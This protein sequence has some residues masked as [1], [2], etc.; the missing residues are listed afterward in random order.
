MADDYYDP[1]LAYNKQTGGTVPGG[2]QAFVYAFEDTSFTTPL[3]ITDESGLPIPYLVASDD[4]I[5]PGF[6]V[7]SGQQRVRVKSGDFVTPMTSDKGRKGDAG[8][9]GAP[10]VGVPALNTGAPGQVVT[11]DGTTAKWATPPAAGSGI[12]GAPNVW[13]SLFPRSSTRTRRRRSR[14]RPRSAVAF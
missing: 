12:S 11:H 14:T 8:A 9:D 10:G 6:I 13:P 5:Y 7:P 3:A 4:G 2:A 1:K